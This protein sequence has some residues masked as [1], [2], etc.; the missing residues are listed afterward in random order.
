MERIIN[1]FWKK[2]TEIVTADEFVKKEY[3]DA[4]TATRKMYGYL[5]EKGILEKISFLYRIDIIDGQTGVSFAFDAED[6][7]PY[8]DEMLNS[9]IENADVAVERLL[10]KEIKPC[11]YCGAIQLS[12]TMMCYR[13]TYGCVD[14][15]WECS[16][17]Q[18][19][20]SGKA[21]EVSD[22]LENKTTKD[23]VHKLWGLYFELVDAA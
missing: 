9:G 22:T 14:K 2:D 5:Y 1:D 12:W 6:L 20:D 19:L 21:E 15:S 18:V 16:M 13:D 3:A 7:K 8:K 23:A 4:V 10:K 11:L 17:V